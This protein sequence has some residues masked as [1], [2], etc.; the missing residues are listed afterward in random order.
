MES[1]WALV[2]WRDKETKVTV[3]EEWTPEVL[4]RYVLIGGE[5]EYLYNG[6]NPY[7]QVPWVR[8]QD[9]SFPVTTG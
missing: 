7:R 3:Y 6:P 9:L 4:L 1:T 5:R 8:M 2:H